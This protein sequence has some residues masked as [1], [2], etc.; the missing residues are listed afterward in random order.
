MTDGWKVTAII[1]IVLFIL[2]TGLF[3]WGWNETV[4]EEQNMNECYYDIC[5]SYVDAWYELDVCTCY[6]YDILGELMVAKTEY[7]R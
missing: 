6:E 5:G 2:E 7:M 1:F 3:I 4:Q